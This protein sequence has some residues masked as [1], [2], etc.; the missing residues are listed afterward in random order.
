MRPAVLDWAFITTTNQ[1][2][3]M[4]IIAHWVP[5]VFCAFISIT[6]LCGWASSS[7]SG[8]GRPVFFAFL[9]MCFFFVAI[10]S[11]SM[12]RELQELRKQLAALEQKWPNPD[13]HP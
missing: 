10:G 13:D 3:I 8:W 12:H 5:V 1:N 2:N 11:T 7:E 4:K 6:A 9:P